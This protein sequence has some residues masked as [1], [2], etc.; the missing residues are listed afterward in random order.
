MLH[1][2]R[3]RFGFDELIL[4]VDWLK[5]TLLELC[6]CLSCCF[7]LLG[8]FIGFGVLGRFKLFQCYKSGEQGN[9]C[10]CGNHWDRLG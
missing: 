8:V 10:F 9:I 1:V 7:S 2:L 3:C 6:V 4:G 5:L